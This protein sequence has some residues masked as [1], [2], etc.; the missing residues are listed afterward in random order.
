MTKSTKQF[1]IVD[2]DPFS[3]F[4]SKTVLLKSFGEVAVKDFLV[5]EEALD[6]I[7][8]EYE[9]SSREEKIVLF[10]DLNMPTITGWEF[11]ELF[12]TFSPSV[13]SQFRIYILSSSIDPLDIERAKQNPLVIDFIEKPLSKGALVELFGG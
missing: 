7:K 3:N 13:R 9:Y 4:L 12:K 10:L 8:E 11:L 2:D 5:P 1:I 6:Y